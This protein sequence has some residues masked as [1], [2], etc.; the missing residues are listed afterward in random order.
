[1]CGCS[2]LADRKESGRHDDLLWCPPFDDGVV[3]HVLYRGF[4]V[5][6]LPGVL[7]SGLDVPPQS[8]FFAT[9]SRAYAWEYAH[10]GDIA[11]MLVLDGSQT[12]P[13]CVYT[14]LT[15]PDQQPV[16]DKST[17][18]S[19]YVY[20]GKRVHTRFDLDH[21]GTHILSYERDYGVWIPGDARA[22]LIAVVLGGPHAR[23]LRT[24]EACAPAGLELV[25]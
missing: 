15:E 2:H 9:N 19:E 8:P 3:K 1:M 24:L 7:E 14:S 17:Y 4:P 10:C 13:S 23:V 6:Q 18:P 16:I 25:R 11:A 20:D 21:R 22:A 12:E 5:A